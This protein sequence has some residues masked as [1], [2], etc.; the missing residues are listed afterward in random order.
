MDADKQQAADDGSPYS[1][2]IIN[3]QGSGRPGDTQIRLSNGHSLGH[4]QA[5]SWGIRVGETSR[6]VVETVLDPAEL[7][8]LLADTVLKIELGRNPLS[9]IWTYYVE[10]F[11]WR[12]WYRLFP[13]GKGAALHSLFNRTGKD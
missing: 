12:V 4:V 10:R 9:F 5:V 6:C 13:R 3:T 8:I 7:K 2:L 11:R 1:Y